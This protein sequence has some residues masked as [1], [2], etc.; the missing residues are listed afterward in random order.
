[1]PQFDLVVN[2]DYFFEVL[3][4]DIQNMKTFI[5]NNIKNK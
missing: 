3:V 1:M 5:K 2:S 4:K